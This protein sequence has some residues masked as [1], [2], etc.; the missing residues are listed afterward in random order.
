MSNSSVLPPQSNNGDFRVHSWVRADAELAKMEAKMRVTRRPLRL[1]IVRHGQSVAQLSPNRVCGA[2]PSVRLTSL[3]REQAAQV[4]RYLRPLLLQQQCSQQAT[5]KATV[6]DATGSPAVP[7]G[8]R[9]RQRATISLHVSPAYRARETCACALASAFGDNCYYTHESDA[10]GDS[11]CQGHTGEAGG[12]TVKIVDKKIMLAK[13][14]KSETDDD[15]L[16]LDMANVDAILEKYKVCIDNRLSEQCRGAAEGQLRTHVYT[17]PVLEGRNRDPWQYRLKVGPA[18]DGGGICESN[19]DVEARVSNY[20][21]ELLLLH[22][23]EAE[24]EET[25]CIEETEEEGEEEEGGGEEC[26]EEESPLPV[27]A[28]AETEASTASDTA[29][30][31]NSATAPPPPPPPPPPSQVHTAIIFS[32]GMVTRH[33]LRHATQGHAEAALRVR[34]YNCSVTE[35]CYSVAPGHSGGWSVQRV[36]DAAHICPKT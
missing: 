19:K 30:P 31:E 25:E 18:R 28:A 36:N 11:R 15:P 5:L 32:H 29:Q 1:L 9:K 6:A 13:K 27:I 2:S 23:E 3:G 20:I 22:E 14:K 8:G 17:A 26:I 10:S 33:F 34:V 16:P 7:D 4:G 21:D 12:E 35:L 24:E